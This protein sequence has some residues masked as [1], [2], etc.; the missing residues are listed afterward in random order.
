MVK[1]FLILNYIFFFSKYFY[2]NHESYAA[3][4]QMHEN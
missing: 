2:V 4:P 1:R 3:Q